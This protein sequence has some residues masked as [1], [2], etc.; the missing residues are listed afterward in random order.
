MWEWIGHHL[1]GLAAIIASVGGIGTLMWTAWHGLQELAA[2][3][4]ERDAAREERRLTKRAEVAAELAQTV[5]R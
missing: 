4:E 5:S 1:G 2:R 3:R